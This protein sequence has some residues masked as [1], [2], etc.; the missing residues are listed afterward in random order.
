M[1]WQE[2]KINGGETVVFR[3]MQDI[4][5]L[6]WICENVCEVQRQWRRKFATEPPT[7]LTIARIRDEFE[8]DGTVHDVHKQR[9]VSP[10]TATSPASSAMTLEQFTRSPLKSA[11]QC[12]LRK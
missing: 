1:E 6:Y 8:A 3:T 11:K 4:L 2:S 5:K 10:G 12:V 9:S 7:Q